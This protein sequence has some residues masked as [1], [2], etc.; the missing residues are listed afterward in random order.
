MYLFFLF[1]IDLQIDWQDCR[2]ILGA[3]WFMVLFGGWNIE[4]FGTSY[5]FILFRM[6]DKTYSNKTEIAKL[7]I[8]LADC[9][10]N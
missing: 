5:K 2:G 7:Y 4:S 3:N 8:T 6:T 1:M 9:C 10:H